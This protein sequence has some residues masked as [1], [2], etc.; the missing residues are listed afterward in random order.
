[1]FQRLTDKFIPDLKESSSQYRARIGIFQGKISIAVNSLFFIVKFTLG[2]I[3][4]AIS[5]IADAIHTLSD[6]IT[7]LIVIWGFKQSVK[8][9]DFKHPYG[10]G[11]AEYVATLIISVLLCVAGIEFIE[12]SID[13]IRNPVI[14]NPEWWIVG[15]IFFTILIKEFTARYAN[16]LSTKI[17]SGLLHADAWHHRVDAIS[18]ALVIGALIAGKFGFTTIDGWVGLSVSLLLIYTGFD[19]ARDSVDDLIGTP[20]NSEELNKIREIALS[21]DK[22]LGV[23]D[24]IMHNYGHDTYVSL[25]VEIDAKKTAA[26]AHNI[27]EEVEMLLIKQMG[28]EPTIHIDPVFPDNPMVKKVRHQLESISKMDKRIK[29]I[30]DIRIVNTNNHNLILFGISTPLGMSRSDTLELDSYLRKALSKVFNAYKIRPKIS[31]IYEN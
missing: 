15:L 19:I 8:P 6:M 10:H 13:R 14:S 17:A 24:I 16:F 12:V 22:A 9:A 21:V 23:H 18:S 7:S 25:H 20:P 31:P 4:G 5:L 30:Y 27:S 11:R 29:N 3:T 1:M 26:E 2:L 28:V